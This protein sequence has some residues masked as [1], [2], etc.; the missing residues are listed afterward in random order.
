M[1]MGPRRRKRKQGCSHQ[2]SKQASKQ[3]GRPPPWS[4]A[5]FSAADDVWRRGAAVRRDNNEGWPLGR[6]SYLGPERIGTCRHPLQGCCCCCSMAGW[7]QPPALPT[8]TW[9]PHGV[10]HS[11][12][13]LLWGGVWAT[14]SAQRASQLQYVACFRAGACLEC[15]LLFALLCWLCV[16]W[17]LCV[18]HA[19]AASWLRHEAS[20]QQPDNTRP[21]T[22]CS[23]PP[24]GG[25]AAI[26]IFAACKR[27]CAGVWPWPWGCPLT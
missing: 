27:L 17:C 10:A 15:V 18:A 1:T 3:R 14:F 24:G 23:R 22:A 21:N 5:A 8:Y 16:V 25:P 13:L 9:L 12:S 7:Q 19:R 26:A 11:A 6:C 20:H 2:A 4:A